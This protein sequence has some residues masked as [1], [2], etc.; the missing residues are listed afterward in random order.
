VNETRTAAFKQEIGE[1][2]LKGSSNRRERALLVT[3]AALLVA[4]VGV[5]LLGAAQAVGTTDAA[6]Q[7]AAIAS[8]GL[9]GIALVAAGAA[10]FV[11]YSQARFMRFWLIRLL[12]EQRAQ[13]DR[14]VEAIDRVI[15]DRSQ[16][17]S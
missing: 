8:G 4:G 1:L 3:G 12:Y 2:K 10:V 13:T 5:A 15:A 17:G 14:V 16:R 9:L 11:R 7:L 6:D